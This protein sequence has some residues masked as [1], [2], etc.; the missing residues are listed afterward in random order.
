MRRL[1]VSLALAALALVAQP[2]PAPAQETGFHTLHTTRRVG[3]KVCMTDHFHAGQSLPSG[4]KSVA[5]RTAIDKWESFTSEEYGKSWGRWS[6]AA[7]KSQKC[8]GSPG[9]I[10]CEVTARPCRSL[11][12][13]RR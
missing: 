9:N 13:G 12:R 6:M 10:V 7:G 5:V 11:R 8:T 1:D 3:S 2:G 4:A